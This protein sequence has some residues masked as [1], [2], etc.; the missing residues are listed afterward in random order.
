MFF[1]GTASMVRIM[2]K[3][4][5]NRYLL[6][7]LAYRDKENDTTWLFGPRKSFAAEQSGAFPRSESDA[8][9]LPGSSEKDFTSVET[10]DE[11][12]SKKGILLSPRRCQLQKPLEDKVSL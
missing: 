4:E 11:L 6:I 12:L 2:I 1:T 7:S 5:C 8:S 10:G 3:C 9:T